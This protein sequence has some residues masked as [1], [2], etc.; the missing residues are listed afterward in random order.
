MIN[1]QSHGNITWVNLQLPTEKEIKKISRR[2]D[3]APHIQREL[4]QAGSE[5]RVDLYPGHIYL[6][7]NFPLLSKQKRSQEV[8]FLLGPNYLL[9]AHY[10]E[11]SPLL[12]ATKK[13]ELKK[14]LARSSPTT[15][16]L[17]FE[18]LGLLYNS[19]LETLKSL[20]D[21]LKEIEENQ[22]IG[23]MKGEF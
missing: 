20:D 9:T 22:K 18:L 13:F 16:E 3:L 5:Q 7:L 15:T 12:V 6:R 10:D 1:D 21:T 23:L 11:I 8:N 17:L 14:L 2:F 19:I 4:G